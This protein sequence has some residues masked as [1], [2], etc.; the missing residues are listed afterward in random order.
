MQQ[1]RSRTSISKMTWHHFKGPTTV[2][3]LIS[4]AAMISANCMVGVFI[5][6][7]TWVITNDSLTVPGR[8]DGKFVGLAAR[9]EASIEAGE[10]VCGPRA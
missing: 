3:N 6:S 9:H 4:Q 1:P 7:T 5:V 2:I 10:E 8:L